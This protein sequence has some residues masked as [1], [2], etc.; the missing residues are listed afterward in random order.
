MKIN[1]KTQLTQN[2]VRFILASDATWAVLRQPVL[3]KIYHDK[4]ASLYP[5][6]LS[7]DGKE[8]SLYGYVFNVMYDSL[9]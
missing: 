3:T 8:L 1:S 4:W 5:R 2:E 7:N 6:P 9:P